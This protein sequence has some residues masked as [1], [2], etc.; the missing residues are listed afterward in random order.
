[1]FVFGARN[2]NGGSRV[3]RSITESTPYIH[4]STLP[5]GHVVHGGA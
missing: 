1:M 5:A 2:G 4:R 3:G